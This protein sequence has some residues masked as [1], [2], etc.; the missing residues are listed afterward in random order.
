MNKKLKKL[1]KE[2]AVI[3][4]GNTEAV[5]QGLN[6]RASLVIVNA[7]RSTVEHRIYD[8]EI[9]DKIYMLT[10]YHDS[11]KIF[12][13]YTVSDFSYAALHLLG[14]EKYCG[15]KEEVLELVEVNVCL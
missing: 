13:R 4:S 10:E 11:G 2:I 1:K 15:E 7:I 8:S 5:K 3:M 6:S 14:V 12:Q 9:I